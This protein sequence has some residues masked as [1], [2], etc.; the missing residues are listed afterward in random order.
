MP[1]LSLALP[2]GV[3][4]VSRW[5]N[6]ARAHE[7][8]LRSELRSEADGPGEVRPV[9]LESWRRSA[10]LH[11]DPDRRDSPVT[12]VDDALAEARATHP[13]RHAMPV[14][15][16]LLVDDAADAGVLVI[17]GDARG[18][19]LWAE[20]DD[21]LRRRA[22]RLHLQAGADWC[23]DAMGTN[24][25]GTALA[26]GDTV[27]VFGSEHYARSVQPWSCTAA[28]IRDPL[29]G[30]TIGVLDITGGASV[31][32]PQSA[33]LV[34]SAVAA[35]EAEL[36]L[37]GSTV[38]V[39]GSRLEVLGRPRGLLVHQGRSLELSLRHTELLLLLAEHPDGLPAS[40]LAWQ[41]YEHDA[42]EVTVR[43]EMSRLR[44]AVPDLLSPAGQYR[45]RAELRTDAMDVADLLGRG[46]HR[47]AVELYRGDL[48]PRSA[49]PGVVALRYRLH[50]WLRNVLL[51][52]GDGEA[53]RRYA[54]SPSGR[55]DAQIWRACLD[56]LAPGSPEKAEAAAVL[57]SLDGELG[58]ATDV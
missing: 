35:V 14:V 52:S 11:V 33:F 16:R 25:I 24:A 4:P 46:D 22:E 26:V 50:G 53:L 57:A 58:L 45:L 9:V 37:L 49:A 15:R 54:L 29:T 48:L 38:A 8:F 10:A 6:T 27:Q 47:A 3:D 30:H 21:D 56:G 51:Q 18:R 1:S 13:L 2:N 34:R 12:L 42:A 32:A 5:R 41:L 36:R 19:I 31:V 28:P 44:K 43:A 40:E 23:E 20:G 17:V 55:D 39:P 7:S